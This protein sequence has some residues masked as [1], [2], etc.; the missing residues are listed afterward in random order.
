VIKRISFVKSIMWRFS[1]FSNK[2]SR[3]ET[4]KYLCRTVC[5]AEHSGNIWWTVSWSLLVGQ[6]LIIIVTVWVSEWMSEWIHNRPTQ[7]Y[8]AP[9]KQRPQRRWQPKWVSSFFRKWVDRQRRSP[10][11]DRDAVPC[12][13]T[14]HRKEV[15]GVL[16]N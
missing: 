5:R 4:E 16:N 10:Q 7:V 3:N 1:I 6:R 8:I 12:R 14:S 13:R 11:F 15:P 9:I 2:S